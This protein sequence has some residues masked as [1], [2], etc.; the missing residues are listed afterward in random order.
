MVKNLPPSVT[1]ISRLRGEGGDYFTVE[2]SVA[3]A[4]AVPSPRET[5]LHLGVQRLTCDHSM[6]LTALRVDQAGRAKATTAKIFAPKFADFTI[7]LSLYTIPK[8]LAS[9]GHRKVSS[10]DTEKHDVCRP[11]AHC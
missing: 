2:P 1:G 5:F 11:P 10:H 4:A 7:S 6:A 9:T 8:L 3:A